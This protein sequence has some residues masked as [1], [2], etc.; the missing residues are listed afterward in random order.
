MSRNKKI[1]ILIL[2]LIGLG[3]SFELCRV[4]YNANF[5]ENPVKSIC[6][7]NDMFDC[8]A[9]A[10]T[11]YSQFLGIPLSLWG[12]I[13]YLFVLFMLFV[14]KIKNIKGLG[15][16]AVFKNPLSYIFCVS[17]LSFCISMVLGCISVFKINSVCIFCFMTYL[18]DFLIAVTAKDWKNGIFY[19]IKNSVSDFLEA[20]K[21]RRYAF[22]FI[23]VMML[24]A[25]VLVY[26]SQSNVL[27]PQILKRNMMIKEF[28]QYK[29]IVNNNVM[30]PSDADVVIDEFIDF[31]CGGC[32]IANLYLHRIVSEF[33]NVKVVQHNVPL[34]ITCNPK[35]QYEGHK[36][37]CL[38]SKYV[39]AAGKQNKYWQMSDILF[40][41]G[42]ENEK[43]ILEKAR[44][45]DFDIKKLK[46]DANSEEVNE[47]IKKSLKLAEEKDISGTPTIY[48]GMKKFL[49]V[50]S[51][52]DFKN[53]VKEAGGRL[54]PGAD[55]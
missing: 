54:K 36:N 46:E 12:V 49:G 25:S 7:I 24:F 41:Q 2:C 17:L 39:I 27:S 19:E 38:K 37:S 3:L 30:G 21:V 40:L 31:N 11:S 4:F 18:I 15:F 9:V 16:L 26:T 5:S 22:W 29:N 14:D 8:D 51:Y 53:I 34:D 1:I 50:N 20:I 45:V 52:P 32:F 35:M 13:L 48:I 55:E 43:E 33:E 47:E 23:L 10:K 42:P 44:L 6:A 28:S